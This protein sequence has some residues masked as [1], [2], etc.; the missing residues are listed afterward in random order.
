MYRKTLRKLRQKINEYHSKLNPQLFYC[1]IPSEQDL[2]DI[3]AG[4]YNPVIQIVLDRD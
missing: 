2:K 4:K 3:E 1:G